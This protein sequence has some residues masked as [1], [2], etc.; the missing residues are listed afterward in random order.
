MAVVLFS[1]MAMLI[2]L[3]GARLPVVQILF[4]RQVV[5]LI[6]IAPLIWRAFPDAL[7]TDRIGLHTFRV[8]AALFAMLTGFTALVHLPLADATAISFAK[9]LFVTVL[10]VV[11]LHEAVGPRRWSATLVG[12][13]GVLVV[14]QP[15][16]EGLNAYALMALASALAVAGIMVSLRL[17]T[18]TERSI[19]IMAYQAIALTVLLAPASLWWW[20]TPTPIEWLG[21]LGIGVFATL[22]QWCNVA[23]FRTGEAAAIAPMDYTRILFATV[24]GLLVFQ[25]VP[26]LA[27]LAGSALIIGATLYTLKRNAKVRQAPRDDEPVS[28]A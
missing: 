27:T 15:T 12:F 3:L 25:E 17:L 21:L 19:T 20:V 23:G 4:V 9:T 2:K 13:V 5:M 26:T 11:V 6:C 16:G 1:L 28:D 8:L 7:K 10:A 22:G 18:R 14:V 24:L